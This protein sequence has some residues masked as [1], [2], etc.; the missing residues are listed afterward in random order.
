MGWFLQL[1]DSVDLVGLSV[2]VARTPIQDFNL[3]VLIE[4][5]RVTT[6]GAVSSPSGSPGPQMVL[7]IFWALRMPSPDTF[8][9]V[10]YEDRNLQVCLLLPKLLILGESHCL[11]QLSNK[12]LIRRWDSERE[13][14]LRRHR[15]RTTKYNRPLHKSR[16]RSTRL[17]AG[18]QVYQSQWNNE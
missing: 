14:S 12:K 18:M 9:C 3:G 7:P 15:T 16:Q 13:L 8:N 11:I 2:Q 17:C 1:M 4:A 6:G 5:P 10:F